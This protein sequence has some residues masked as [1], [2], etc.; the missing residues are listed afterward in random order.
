MNPN[1]IFIVADDLGF[2]DLGC[3]GGRDAKFGP[4]SPVLDALAAGGIRFTDGYANSPVCSPTRFALITG[5]YQYRL[6]GAAEEPISAGSKGSKTLGLPPEHPTV[7]SLLKKAGYKTALIGKWHLG[8]PP[9]FGPIRSGYD[10]F[11]G[12]MSGGVDYFTH[13]G[14]N[15]DHDLY[16]D[17]QQK[18]EEGYLTDLLSRHAVD[19]VDR[20]AAAREPFFLSLHYTAPHWPW[21]TRD[22]AHVAPEVR[23]NL[24]HLHGG[25][26]HT[27]HRM[28]H[29]MDEGIGWV[30]EALRRHGIADN[31]LVV[32]TSD[33]GGERFSDNW[34][35]V[36]GKM[37]LTEGGIRVPWIAHWPAVIPAGSVSAQHC[38]TMDWSATVLQAARAAPDAEYPL[39]GQSLLQ[40]LQSPGVQFDRPMFWRMKHRDQRA[41][42]SGDWKYLRV[43]GHDYLFDVTTDARE[44]ANLAG[45]DPERLARMRQAWEA[46]NDTMPAIPADASVKLGYG[47]QDMPQR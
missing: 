9:H 46:W 18:K 2:A 21:E 39:D 47:I 28:I 25:N 3:Y 23:T 30:M 14:G 19:Y 45:R 15:G 38:M 26:I 32:F 24:F 4:V 20:M 37:D 7:P 40:V 42:R 33:N 43:D 41:H 29:H 36:G 22:D 17:E 5:R 16:L 12:P 13:C 6:R 35:L 1:I 10:E 34:P 11:F 31:T 44:R 27:Y 8:Y